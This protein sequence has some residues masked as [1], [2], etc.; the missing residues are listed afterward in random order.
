MARYTNIKCGNCGHSFTGGYTPGNTSVLGPSKVHCPK[1]K[2]F[3]R[4][5]SKP[6]SQFNFGDHLVF[7]IGRVIKML[8][9]GLVYG[10]FLGYLTGIN[11]AGIIIGIIGNIIFNYFNIKYQINETEKEED[12]L[13]GLDSKEK[14][15]NIINT[16]AQTA[17][18]YFNRGWA[19]RK[20]LGWHKGA[21]EDYTKAIEMSTNYAFAYY[22]R[23][24]AKQE[25]KDFKGAIEDYTKLIEIDSVLDEISIQTN[26]TI[27]IGTMEIPVSFST[28]GVY[29]RR[30]RSKEL[31]KDFKGAIAD[32]TEAIG[33]D[34]KR[35]NSYYSR[36]VSKFYLGDMIGACKD[37]RKA[38]ELG[39]D[40][41]ILIK[42]A[43]N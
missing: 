25:L 42:K 33:I 2:I 13:S 27:I 40:A 22:E 26:P 16:E 31:L 30:A 35:M 29:I 24:K 6:Y 32:Y 8:L 4:T 18:E 14:Y 36:G 3:N 10:G 41:S 38:Q 9:L 37:A 39:D 11:N 19:K 28:A 23:A 43:C 1:C 34:P 5:S 12:K 17:I 21:I 7:W 20:E 15:F